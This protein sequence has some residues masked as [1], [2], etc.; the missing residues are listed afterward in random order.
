M[1]R[2]PTAETQVA[3]P[4]VAWLRAGG[5]DVYQEVRQG[6]GARACDIV[7]TQGR[8]IWAVEVK[9]RLSNAVLEQAAYWRQYAHFASVAVPMRY[10]ED[11]VQKV[12]IERHGLGVIGVKDPHVSYY[13]TELTEEV[14]DER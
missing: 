11:W 3:A 10:D 6:A 9:T 2:W 5:W 8:L 12:F 14:S 4:V 1:I 7:A 13:K